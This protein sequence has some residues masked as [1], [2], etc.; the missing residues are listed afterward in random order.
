MAW[1]A[2]QRTNGSVER[3]A[4]SEFS[5]QTGSGDV[6][7]EWL[8]SIDAVFEKIGRRAERR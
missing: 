3:P 6:K 8:G 1:L 4:V 7:D 2:S 5:E